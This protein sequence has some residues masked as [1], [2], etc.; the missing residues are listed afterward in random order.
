[1][2]QLATLSLIIYLSEI[3]HTQKCPAC[4]GASLV[5]LA[6]GALVPPET[7]CPTEEKAVVNLSSTGQITNEAIV[8]VTTFCPTSYCKGLPVPQTVLS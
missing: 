3:L 5:G 8:S 1:M 2:G 7:K 4:E 6:A